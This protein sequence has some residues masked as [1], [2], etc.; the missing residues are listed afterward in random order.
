MS[1][2]QPSSKLYSIKKT[3]KKGRKNDD[4]A[5]KQ[6]KRLA[7][8]YETSQETNYFRFFSLKQQGEEEYGEKL[9]KNRNTNEAGAEHQSNNKQ[10]SSHFMINLFVMVF[11]IEIKYYNVCAIDDNR[12]ISLIVVILISIVSFHIKL[13]SIPSH[14][15]SMI[16]FSTKINKMKIQNELKGCRD[17]FFERELSELWNRQWRERVKIE[18]Y[19]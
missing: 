14:C 9:T 15:V 19:R 11:F 5:S 7:F 10:L 13:Y 2:A 6:S 16:D 8:F 18:S 3:L 4:K 12:R 1:P 17:E